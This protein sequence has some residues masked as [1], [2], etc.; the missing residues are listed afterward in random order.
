MKFN[1]YSGLQGNCLGH[2]PER[3]MVLTESQIIIK[4]A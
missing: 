3:P 2:H 1:H 4:L